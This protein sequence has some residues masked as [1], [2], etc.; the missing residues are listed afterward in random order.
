MKG[1]KNMNELLKLQQLEVEQIGVA[2]ISWSSCDSNS[3]NKEEEAM[4]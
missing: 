3:C 1:G 4:A 2:A